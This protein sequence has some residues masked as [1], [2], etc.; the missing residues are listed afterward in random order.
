MGKRT[1]PGPLTERQRAILRLAA[2]VYV[3]TGRPVSSTAVARRGPSLRLSTATIRASLVELEAE[4][5]LVQPHVSAG[6]APT[7]LGM[8]Y[9][10]DDLM[11]PRLR[12]WDRTHL[13]ATA[14]D[15]VNKAD[16]LVTATPAQ[17]PLIRRDWL[18][19][20]LHITAMGSDAP[21]KNEL[22]P[23]ILGKADLVVADSLS[24]CLERGEIHQALKAERIP[25]D[26]AI[27]LGRIIL[28]DSPG[29][30]S[31]DQITVA[32]L[33]GVAVQDIQIAKAVYGAISAGTVP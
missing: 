1:K 25:Q 21:E 4:G 8:R 5:L 30:T 12:P 15:V 28:G 19:P 20:G 18:H 23:S 2:E 13:A 27:E 7:E 31:E 17:K 14:E 22:D 10:L 11:R 3:E 26:K 9:Y 16:V 24:Q 32:D 6:R 29:R 33:T